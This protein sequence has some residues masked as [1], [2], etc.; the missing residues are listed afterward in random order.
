MTYTLN[1]VYEVLK[2]YR[3]SPHIP[4]SETRDYRWAMLLPKDIGDM[5]KDILYVCR[6]TQALML[7]ETSPGHH[8]LCIRDRFWDADE[9]EDFLKG[10]IVIN[11]NKDVPWLLNLIQQRFLLLAGWVSQMKQAVIDDSGYQKLLDISEPILCNFT[12]ILDA[13]YK[14]VAY[15]RNLPNDDPIN[16]E[17]VDKGYHSEETIK[18]FQSRKRFKLYEEEHGLIVSPPGEI[19]RYECVNKLSRYGGIIQLHTVMVCSTIPLSN[20][21]TELF[22]I[23]M[24]YIEIVFFREQKKLQTPF[25]IYS[26][27]ISDMLYGDLVSPHLIGEQAKRVDIPFNGNFDVYRIVFEDNA[28]ILIGR[29][30]QDLSSYLPR[31]KIISKDYEICVLNIYDENQ[32]EDETK[33]NLEKIAPILEKYK[34]ICGVSEIF[35]SLSELKDSFMQATR[36][37]GIGYKLYRLGNYWGTGKEIFDSFFPYKNER[38]FHYNDVYIFYMIYLAESG[39]LNAFKNTRCIQAIETLQ[40]HDKEHDGNLV[41]ILYCYLLSERR[42]TAA[43]N[44]LH[45]H[46]NNVLYH[47]GRITEITGVEL[48]NYWVR[49]KLMIAFHCLEL[50]MANAKYE[51]NV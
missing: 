24:K 45:M 44:L 51:G 48:D 26:S 14:L 18:L 42:A 15:T 30:I 33:G 38:I 1:M 5:E 43:G 10:I 3:G 32:T 2:P 4:K 12:I 47:I 49:L 25:T 7:S 27:F 35:S 50:N 11:E 31:A 17:L 19:S 28:I 29:F 6:L 20:E 46:R 8:F 40:K 13:T 37:Q 16:I 41:E 34:A 9:T 22:S 23:L 21:L 36:A 39:R